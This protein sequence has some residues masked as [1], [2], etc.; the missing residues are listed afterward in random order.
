[1]SAPGPLVP[2]SLGSPEYAADPAAWFPVLRDRF[3]L[4]RDRILGGW[5]LSRHEDVRLA[6]RDPRFSTRVYRR[7]RPLIGR[8]LLEAD[9]TEHARLRA[10]LSPP[11]RGRA[12]RE[13]LVPVIRRTAAGLVDR[14]PRDRPFDVVAEYFHV[15][16]ALV[17]AGALGLPRRDFRAFQGWYEAVLRAANDISGDPAVQEAGL[18]AR[19][20]F[21]TYLGPLVAA[22]RAEPRD[23]LLS[24][25]CAP[26][27]GRTPLT[28]QAVKDFCVLLMVAG[29]ESTDKLL[30]L[31]TRNL[32]DHPAQRDA[33]TAD[34]ALLT[35]AVLETL[36]RDPPGQVIARETVAEVAVSGGTIPA[37]ETVHLLLGAANRDP[38]L[39]ARPDDFDVFREG[40][41]PE[42][43]FTGGAVLVAFGSGRHFCA[44]A[45]LA[46]AETEIALETLFDGFPGLRYAPGF[47]PRT[48][49]V[50]VRAPRQLLVR[51]PPICRW[52]PS[53]P[54]N[55][56][57]I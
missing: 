57:A 27:G 43:E 15:L 23:D 47:R 29:G 21:D 40:L 55:G 42:R 14:L 44:G 30:A 31:V 22:R 6:F 16:P 18:R 13:R 7:Q 41:D 12:L 25:L 49:G 35:R 38:A 32:L 10:A 28:E 26:G 48:T 56:A 20:E 33:V 3:P 5:L 51:D 52:I 54:P 4:V 8:S 34:R 53:C 1:M 36:R 2:P 11:F 9:G 39:F 17:M 24:A 37:G 46:R 50:F 45:M 19:A